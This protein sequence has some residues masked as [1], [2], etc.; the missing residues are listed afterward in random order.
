MPSTSSLTDPH[1][2]TSP[3]RPARRSPSRPAIG[4]AVVLTAQLMLMLDATVVNV[5]LPHIATDLGFTPASLSWVINAFTLAI[6]GLLLLGGRLGDVFGRRRVFEA[7]LT[8]FTLASLAGGFATSPAW[9]VAT[10]AAQGAGAA[11]A[12]PGVLAL[13]TTSA[14]DEAARRRG[15][16]LFSAVIS[17]GATLGLLLGGIVTEAGS[18]RWTLF[19]NVPIGIAVL[20][21]LRRFVDETP[22]RPGGF[23]LVGAALATVG[24][25]AVVWALIGAPENGW[26]SARTPGRLGRRRRHP[27]RP[28]AGRGTRRPPDHPTGA[29]AQPDPRDLAGG[30]GPGH[31]GAVLDVLH[32]GAVPPAGPR[33]RTPRRRP[34][35]PAPHPGDL[36]DVAGDPEAARAVRSRRR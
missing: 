34:G 4:L 10:R 5:A 22:R 25:V 20:V 30:H 2:S 27:C 3:P 12:S 9:L 6:G 1:P 33:L 36:R 18:W 13:I 28:V 31:R 32:H 15:L 17:G 11:L 8:L 23:D 35:L 24:P 14:P 16:A 21:V 7:G 29:A 26:L 19:I